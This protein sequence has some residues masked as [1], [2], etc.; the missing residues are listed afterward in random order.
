MSNESLKWVL[1]LVLFP[2]CALLMNAYF[3]QW[4]YTRL[5]RKR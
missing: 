4:I 1:R 2:L 3:W 5:P